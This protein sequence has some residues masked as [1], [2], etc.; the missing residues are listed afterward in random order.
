MGR[1][2]PIP[3]QAGEGSSKYYRQCSPIL[4]H[5][6]VFLWSLPWPCHPSPA[7]S[8]PPVRGC[9]LIGKVHWVPKP[10]YSGFKFVLDFVLEFSSNQTGVNST[11][12]CHSFA[13]R[14][15]PHEIW[16]ARSTAV[17]SG[18]VYTFPRWLLFCRY[19]PA[20]RPL[21]GPGGSSALCPPCPLD[22]HV[23]KLVAGTLCPRVYISL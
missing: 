14:C 11:K 2:T 19:P 5:P 8:H 12:A 7:S 4:F 20:Q 1:C 22:H 13:E 18:S 17:H 3:P 6:P 10:D 9:C 16:F 23:G 15:P 21:L